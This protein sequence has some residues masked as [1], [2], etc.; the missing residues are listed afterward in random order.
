MIINFFDFSE[1]CGT[2]SCDR[3]CLKQPVETN[4]Y[5]SLKQVLTIAPIL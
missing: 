4:S 5:F 2:N 3:N 1:F